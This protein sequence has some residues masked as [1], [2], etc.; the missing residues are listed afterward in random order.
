MI[1]KEVAYELP[2]V[3]SEP[4]SIDNFFTEEM[5]LRVKKVIES[6]DLGKESLH[7]NTTLGRWEKSGIAFDKDIEEYCLQKAKELFNDNSLQK[8]YFFATRYQRKE[9]CI[10]QLHEHLDQNGTQ[11]TI[12]ITIENTAEW[13]LDI[14]GQIF[15]QKPNQ[16]VMFGGQQHIHSRPPYP[17]KDLDKYIT[18]LFL[19][20][21]QPDHWMQTDRAN[22]AK[23]YG[24]DANIRFF[25]ENRFMPIPDTPLSQPWC[26][27]H[28]Y[29]HILGL[30]DT[31]VGHATDSETE[32][33]DTTILEEK[34]L[35][36]GIIEYTISRKSAHTLKGLIQNS[37]IQQWNE[38]GVL[39]NRGENP[40]KKNIRNCFGYTI[41]GKESTCHPQDPIR[42]ST[43][44]VNISIDS[45][46]ER[47]RKKYGIAEVFAEST[48]LLRY[49]EGGHF[50]EHVDHNK[51]LPRVISASMFL[52]DNFD[53]GELEFKEFGL[54]IKPEAGKIIVFYST[55]PYTH[56]VNVVEC[57][58]RYSAVKWYRYL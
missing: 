48:N 13:T 43:E 56:K 54:T 50:I 26:H 4:K 15:D 8:T 45:A 33:V 1:K 2:D 44:S 5:F 37:L 9:C 17:T 3:L 12:D 57:G 53:G 42:I 32:L 30:Y 46:V 20:F 7:Y 47:F 39:T 49:E 55:Q 6:T 52:N 10:P 58:I 35:A 51:N 24:Q 31:I 28:S 34:E 11:T 25:N 40:V 41:K 22:G 16:A 38:A 23:K 19:H 18:V 29:Y 36:K 27:C 21:T 14:D